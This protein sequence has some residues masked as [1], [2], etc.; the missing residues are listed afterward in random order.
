MR[1][2]R[3]LAIARRDLALETRGRRGWVLPAITA[4]LMLPAST[5]DLGAVGRAPDAQVNVAGDVPAEVLALDTVRVVPIEF[6]QVYFQYDGERLVVQARA[7][8]E[9]I[10]DALEPSPT[11]RFEDVRAPFKMP[12]RSLLLALIASSLLTGAVAESLPGERSRHTLELL[13]AAAVTRLELVTGK[14][15]AWAGYGA[16]TALLAASISLVAGRQEAGPWLVTL[17]LVPACTIALGLYLLRRSADVVGGSTVSIRVLPALLSCA[18]IV[19]MLVSSVHPLVGAAVPLGGALL[20]AG[21]TWPGW[22]PQ[23]VA[24]VS[25]GG[26]TAALLWA[27]AR[28]IGDDNSP[29]SNVPPAVRDA[30]TVGAIASAAWWTPIAG[31][32][33]W[34]A[35]GNPFIAGQLPREPGILAGS[36]LLLLTALVLSARGPDIPHALGLSR[37]RLS[38]LAIGLGAGL[39]LFATS[40]ISS[41]SP[42]TG[43]PFLD[44]A[45]ERLLGAVNPVWAG[46][47]ALILSVFAHELLF[48][49]WLQR[50]A[51]PIAA[52][53]V[54]VVAISPLDPVGG[55]VAGC[56]LSAAAHRAGTVWA[57]LLAHL[58]WIAAL[59]VAS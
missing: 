37:P 54:Y 27:T 41:L 16:A 25:T 8:P 3:L 2:S 22:L 32:V 48:R 40:G 31:P 26:T 45:G 20:T 34:A 23:L 49:G 14:W 44:D 50:A 19:A 56:L 52:V 28:D 36:L 59:I 17:P 11:I 29:R 24:V 35:A 15:L 10:P 7:L 38:T 53:L 13:L 6:A 12:G 30:L 42:L 5:V 1:W 55:L 47:S 18:G 39:L 9:A 51:G 4:G 33:L 58:V 46:P 57:A 43:S 21:D